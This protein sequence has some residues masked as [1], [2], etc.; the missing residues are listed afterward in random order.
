MKQR[1]VLTP[2]DASNRDSHVTRVSGYK[3]VFCQNVHCQQSYLLLH[4]RKKNNVLKCWSVWD[5]SELFLPFVKL[6]VAGLRKLPL[7]EQLV[8]YCNTVGERILLSD[9]SIRVLFMNPALCFL[10][11]TL[12]IITFVFLASVCTFS[13]CQLCL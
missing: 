8:R 4:F 12:C 1:F 3:H 5:L 13:W 9:C 10:D 2:Q 6:C 11:K 7:H